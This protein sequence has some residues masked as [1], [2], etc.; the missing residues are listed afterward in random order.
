LINRADKIL[1][2]KNQ[3]TALVEE[4]FINTADEDYVM[5]RWCFLNRLSRHFFWNAAQSLEKYL[6]AALLL[7]GF[8]SKGYNHNLVRLF[9]K[10]INFAGDII[11]QQLK[12]PKQ[13]KLFTDHEELL[14]PGHIQ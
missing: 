5:A 10:A 13:V 11:P 2:L 6:K 8:S 9:H 4:I 14:S 3:K 12:K 1:K 7:N